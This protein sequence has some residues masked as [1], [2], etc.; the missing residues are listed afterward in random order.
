MRGLIRE[1]RVFVLPGFLVLTALIMTPIA[2]FTGTFSRAE[3]QEPPVQAFP[4]WRREGLKSQVNQLRRELDQLRADH[5]ALALKVETNRNATAFNMGF[6]ANRL[7]TLK[8]ADFAIGYE[9]SDVA[10]V[11]HP[12]TQPNK[13]AIISGAAAAEA[14]YTAL[15]TP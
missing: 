13:D 4:S 15:T 5:D 14:F 9:L 8:E 7:K 3:A 2:I 10:G 12:L 1:Y 6:Q 11:W